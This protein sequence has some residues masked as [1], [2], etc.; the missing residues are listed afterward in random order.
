M[1]WLGKIEI[2]P[3]F[4]V[5]QW[6][7]GD[8]LIS[9]ICQKNQEP[10]RVLNVWKELSSGD[11]ILSLKKWFHYVHHPMQV[12]ATFVWPESCHQGNMILCWG[13]MV[14]ISKGYSHSLNIKTRLSL[15]PFHLSFESLCRIS[16]F[17]L[18]KYGGFISMYPVGQIL[19]FA[20]LNC[21]GKHG[22]ATANS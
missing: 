7:L 12:K 5:D 6:S 2:Q 17:L 20:G 8:W 1:F 9:C 16:S 18:W 15:S 19:G 11:G 21:D 22:K 13:P 4:F 3:N 10:K 14:L